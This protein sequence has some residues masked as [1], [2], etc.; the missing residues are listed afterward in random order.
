[1]MFS[2]RSYWRIAGVAAV[3]LTVLMAGWRRR[4]RD[5]E[6]FGHSSRQTFQAQVIH[7]DA[8]VDSTPPEGMPGYVAG[9]IY[10]NG[11]SRHWA[12]DI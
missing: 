12:E 2:I 4:A 3:L 1:M 10:N 6:D 5:A 7:P 11:I 8:P 9:Q